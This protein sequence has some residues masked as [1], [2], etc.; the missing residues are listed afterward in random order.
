MAARVEVDVERSQG[1]I[2]LRDEF[3]SV[4]DLFAVHSCSE[5]E[6]EGGSSY[7]EH[8][9]VAIVHERV[10]G[11]E[12][13]DRVAEVGDDSAQGQQEG[14]IFPSLFLQPRCVLFEAFFKDEQVFERVSVG[15]WVEGGAPGSRTTSPSSVHVGIG[16]SCPA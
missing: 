9:D 12:D 7:E 13:K 11:G 1:S 16:G 2:R 10:D 6:D 15:G 8:G 5:E 14:F 3:V 4:G